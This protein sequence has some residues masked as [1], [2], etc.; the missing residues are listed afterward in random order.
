MNGNDLRW[1]FPSIDGNTTE[2]IRYTAQISASMH[3]GDIVQNSVNVTGGGG[4]ASTSNIISI[5]GQIPQTG[6]S[7]LMPG[8]GNANL[9]PF[10]PG[11]TE[12]TSGGNAWVAL[13]GWLMTAGSGLGAGGFMGRRLFFT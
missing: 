9:T 11:I 10:Q 12:S 2:T 3:N 7:W 8:S 6:V 4:S 1:T 13:L 5:I